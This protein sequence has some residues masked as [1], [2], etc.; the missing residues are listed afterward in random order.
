[1]YLAVYY[2]EYHRPVV[3]CERAASV[4]GSADTDLQKKTPPE[5]ERGGGGAIAV[6]HRKKKIRNM[7]KTYAQQ[8]L[9][10]SPSEEAPHG[11]EHQPGTKP[12]HK[13]KKTEK[14]N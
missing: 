3:W 12:M 10:P 6:C 2:N 9:T 13:N 14:K 5:E 1:M 4:C 7:K 8:L 11:T